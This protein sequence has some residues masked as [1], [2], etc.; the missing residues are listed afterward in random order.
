MLIRTVFIAL[1][2]ATIFIGQTAV[3]TAR[4]VRATTAAK[5]HET[6]HEPSNRDPLPTHAVIS[7][8]G[9]ILGAAADARARAFLN[10]T[11][12]PH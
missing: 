11:G 7:H 2:S 9:A 6:V 10:G 3:S 1:L 8:H 5:V 4:V 12:L